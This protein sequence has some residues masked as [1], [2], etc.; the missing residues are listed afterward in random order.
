VSA[1]DHTGWVTLVSVVSP[2]VTDDNIGFCITHQIG[3]YWM[4]CPETGKWVKFEVRSDL[5]HP[6][7][8]HIEEGRIEYDCESCG[9]RHVKEPQNGPSGSTRDRP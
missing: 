7:G 5:P 6:E 3:T 8:L 1:P 9:S 4:Q 2:A